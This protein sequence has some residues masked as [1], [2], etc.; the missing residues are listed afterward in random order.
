M[1]NLWDSWGRV[2]L[3]FIGMLAVLTIGV[4]QIPKLIPTKAEVA[5][6][7]YRD[8]AKT[9]GKDNVQK[10]DYTYGHSDFDCADYSKAK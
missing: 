7:S 9:C 5:L 1:K 3:V 2:S 8:A 10:H 4:A 6:K